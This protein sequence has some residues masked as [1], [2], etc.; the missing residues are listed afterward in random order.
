M[1]QSSE[2]E[3][4]KRNGL[5][6]IESRSNVYLERWTWTAG[7]EPLVLH[8]HADWQICEY[9]N[10]PGEY[11]HRGVHHQFAAKSFVVIPP[12]E[13]H[14]SA[15]SEVRLGANYRVWYFSE[16]DATA[17]NH[18][19]H[20]ALGPRRRPA[21]VWTA[22]QLT[23]VM[24]RLAHARPDEQLEFAE[25]LMAGVTG[26]SPAAYTRTIARSVAPTAVE[27]A[28]DYI[29]DNFVA[30]FSIAEVAAAVGLSTS[31]LAH[32]FRARFHLSPGAF[33][34]SL[35]IDYARRL[36]FKGVTIPEAAARAGFADQSHLTRNFR[37]S[38][39]P[40]P[41]AYALLAGSFKTQARRVAYAGDRAGFSR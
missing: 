38:V 5:D 1:R 15:D 37:R 13:V 25:L 2:L 23:R 39:G 32:A 6:S 20:A 29:C 28:K 33:G 35:R 12:D 11:F 8:T 36:L 24:N 27:R 41:G 3:L 21:T 9:L 10:E 17:L 26:T 16:T 40:T 34:M 22:P 30:T 31:R 18:E 4:Q 7:A 19:V 14:R